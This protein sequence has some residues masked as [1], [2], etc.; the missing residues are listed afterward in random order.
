[1]K[2]IGLVPRLAI[3]AHQADSLA[4][5]IRGWGYTSTVEMN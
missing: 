3:V 1:M 4:G 2:P 5:V